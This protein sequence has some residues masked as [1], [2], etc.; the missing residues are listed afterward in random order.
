MR[1]RFVWWWKIIKQY[2][3]NCTIH[4][5]KYLVNDQ[6]SYVER[7]FW[8]IF[9]ALSWYGCANMINNV[10]RNYIQYPIAL[11][12]ETTYLDW[13]TPFP[14]VAFCFTVIS[15]IK[16]LF[17]GNPGLFTNSP[18]SKSLRESSEHLLSLYQ[19]MRVPCE[20]FLAECTWNNVKFDCCTEFK[21][22]RKTGVGY[23]VAMNTFHSKPGVH[24][25]NNLKLPMLNNVDKSDIPIKSGRTTR[26]EF[27]MQDTFNE[28]GVKKIAVEHRGCRFPEETQT[29]NLFNVYSSDSCYLE[30]I[31]ERMIK[32]CGCVNF[33]YFMP[34]GARVCN[35]T[36]MLCIIENKMNIDVQSLKN[37]GCLPDCEGTSLVI[38]HLEPLEYDSPSRMYGRLHFSLLSHPTMRYRRYVVNDLLDV[39]GG[40]VTNVFIS[41]TTSKSELEVGIAPQSSNNEQS[42]SDVNTCLNLLTFQEVQALVNRAMGNDAAVKKFFLRSY[43]DKKL[44]FLGSHQRLSVEIKTPGKRDILSLFVK[45]VPYDLPAQ[46]EYV[47][48]KCAF[49][50]EKIF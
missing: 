27:T 12:T 1:A 33:Y 26:V 35:G 49:L 9:C 25:L 3:T 7:L 29:D 22:L 32:L 21:E 5:V 23:C 14:T 11:T 45:V 42:H 41:S 31:I 44:G 36:E 30:V 24:L 8:L 34:R 47:L 38:N 15:P 48:D 50:K 18:D 4:G 46:A 40:T 17:K 43:S 37:E 39:I 13:Q 2:L 16:K 19:T 28:D 10:V 20:E 6:L